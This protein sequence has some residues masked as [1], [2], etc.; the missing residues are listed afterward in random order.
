MPRLLALTGSPS[1][2]SRTALVADLILDRFADAGYETRHLAVR[3][4]PAA[5]L[6]AARTG[7]P[8]IREALAAVAAADG[9]IVATPVYKAAYT[10]L[11]KSFL[12]LLPQTGLAGKTVLP[13]ATGGSLAHVLALDYAL[14][15]VLTAL[16]AR[17]VTSG[18]F[19]LDS[20]V[21][22]GP[23]GA[24]LEPAAAVQL[25][26]AVTEFAATLPPVGRPAGSAAARVLSSAP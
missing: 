22:R 25:D 13:L 15:P 3:D 17:H 19:L 5:D 26:Q 18:R 16:G 6:L 2:V 11:L 21:S 10:G 23:S 24:L 9:I 8:E 1:A 7:Q 20:T 14:R 4:L 12:D